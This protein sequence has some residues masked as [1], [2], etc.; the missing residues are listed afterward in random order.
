MSSADLEQFRQR[1]L[2][3]LTRTDRDL[4]DPD[5]SSQSTPSDTP[6]ADT[7]FRP[8]KEIDRVYVVTDPETKLSTIRSV[9]K[10]S[11]KPAIQL[12]EEAIAK[13]KVG[14]LS[15]AVRLYRLAHKKNPNIDTVY[16]ELHFS[17]KRNQVA[18]N[19]A[20]DIEKGLSDLCLSDPQADAP[21]LF[22][23]LPDEIIESILL[24]TALNDIH[25]FI[26]LI[27]LNKKLNRLGQSAY[28]WK[29]I[30]LA[31]Y[32]HETFEDHI[33]P[34]ELIAPYTEQER[35]VCATSF[36]SDWKLMYRKRPFIRFNGV[37]IST[38]TYQRPGLSEDTWNAPY[39]IVTY[40][41]YLR[42]FPNR[43]C[44]SFLSTHEPSEIVPKLSKDNEELYR[45]R[46][47]MSENGRLHI[48]T[49]GTV[50][51]YI[52]YMDLTMKSYGTRRHN[53]LTWNAFWS[54]NRLT[55]NR[56]EFSL[57]HDKPFMFSRVL[58]YD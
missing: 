48:E 37:Y 24:H 50:S 46:W 57:R 32:L 54:V 13:E 47:T 31:T 11:N 51:R 8:A 30:C 34:R 45:G 15:E 9:A 26:A 25:D 17:K 16:K 35:L 6:A 43:S 33:P 53:R 1:W 20:Q 3:D 18:E 42:F 2:N 52:F 7:Y 27:N 38:C 5:E 56:A 14:Q 49:E 29:N 12:Y 39:H 41:R 23:N 44:V 21:S 40:Y 10:S 4:S 58:S 36:N 22:L 19:N 28:V 55:D